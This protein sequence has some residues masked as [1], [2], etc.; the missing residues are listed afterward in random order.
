MSIQVEEGETF[1]LD[2]L[3]LSA[4]FDTGNLN[5][6]RHEL[7]LSVQNIE[8]SAPFWEPESAEETPLGLRR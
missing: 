4:N 1:K 6:F 5:P 7:G 3:N 2:E 8:I